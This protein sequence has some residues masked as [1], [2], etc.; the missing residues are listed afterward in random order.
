MT[1]LRFCVDCK[2]CRHLPR[3][4]REPNEVWDCL[5]NTAVFDLVTG[6]PT[7][8]VFDCHKARRQGGNCGPEGKLFE[9]KASLPPSG[10]GSWGR[11]WR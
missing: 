5:A 1:A 8:I 2:H 3:S 10:Q 4:Q 6:N 9:P 11:G 7:N